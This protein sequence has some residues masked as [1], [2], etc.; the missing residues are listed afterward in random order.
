MNRT[1]RADKM[2]AFHCRDGYACWELDFG[3]VNAIGVE[4][5]GEM[6]RVLDWCC[7]NFPNKIRLLAIKSRKISPGGKPI[8]S[9]GADLKERASWSCEQILSHLKRQRQLVHRLR[10]SPF[11]SFVYVDGIALGLGV[12]MCLAADF[13]ATSPRSTFA[14]PEYA[15]G[16]IPGAGGYVWAKYLAKDT[17]A[18]SAWMEQSATA[19]A[20]HAQ[21]LGIVDAIVGNDGEDED[22]CCEAESSADAFS[23]DELNVGCIL[24]WLKTLTPEQQAEMKKKRCKKVDFDTLFAQEQAEYARRLKLRKNNVFIV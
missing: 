11:W 18:A 5:L 2:C 4:A 13:A 22:S 16:I 20:R 10:A 19:D 8:F 7:Q 23:A 6:T 1:G 12:E 21:W 24:E 9:A 17:A 15:L 3:K 14:L